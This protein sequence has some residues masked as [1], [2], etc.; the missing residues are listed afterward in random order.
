VREFISAGHTVTTIGQNQDILTPDKLPPGNESGYDFF[1]EIENGRGSDGKFCWIQPDYNLQ[2]PS[3]AIL[4][5]SH[6]QPDLHQNI[7]KYYN[8]IFYAVYFRRDLFAG[9]K[10]A[11]WLPNATDLLWFG[12]EGF[13]NVKIKSAFGFFGSKGGL[14]RATP[15]IEICKRQGWTCDVRQINGAFKPKFPHTGEAMRSC[16]I[17]FNRGQK[18]DLNLRIFESGAINRPLVCDLDPR[19]GLDLLFTPYKHFISYNRDLSGL[20]EAMEFC[21]KSPEKA[22]IISDNMYEEIRSKH[23]VKHRVARILEIVS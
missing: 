1:L 18:L 6:G 21:V 19:S 5:D 20:E 11:H 12:Y 22:I 15:M 8:H 16:K 14:D 23:L 3:A 10:S 17:L 2:I 7:A 13:R 4:T 9:H